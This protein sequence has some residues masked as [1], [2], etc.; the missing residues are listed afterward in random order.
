MSK[1]SF[2]SA[3]E[4]MV[5]AFT[6]DMKRLDAMLEQ[7]TQLI[8]ADK[9]PIRLVTMLTGRLAAASLATY[10]DPQLRLALFNTHCKSIAMLI[11]IELEVETDGQAPLDTRAGH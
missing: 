11:G 4:E 9:F 10:K 2:E 1:S 5:A 6:A 7:V 8:E 3:S